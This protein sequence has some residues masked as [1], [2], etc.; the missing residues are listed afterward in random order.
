MSGH[1]DPRSRPSR[2]RPIGSR[3]LQSQRRILS[4][5]SQKLEGFVATSR[6]SSSKSEVLASSVTENDGTSQ[7]HA[8]SKGSTRWQLGN[9]SGG[10]FSDQHGSETWLEEPSVESPTS[11]MVDE[12][13][14]TRS[15]PG[16]SSF[17]LQKKS[18]S[19]L[20]N[21]LKASTSHFS[22]HPPASDSD[23]SDSGN[24]LARAP[25][26]AR[27]ER[28]RQHVMAASLPAS[29]PP[30]PRILP[31]PSRPQTPKLPRFPRLG[32]RQVVEH[33]REAAVDDSRG[34]ADELLQICWSAR[35]PDS[36]RQGK[37][38][39]DGTLSSTVGS[40]LHLP[41]VS[42]TTLNSFASGSTLVQAPTTQKVFNIKRPASTVS[43][44]SN[45][46]LVMLLHDAILRYAT[47]NS[48]RLPHETLV[49][50]TL[51]KPF[52]SS[53]N[54]QNVDED[55]WTAIEAFEVAVR[56]WQP[57]SDDVRGYILRFV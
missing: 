42:S 19:S 4:T 51:L 6:S 17:P 38:E 47:K 44:G 11:Y 55:R 26:S 50:S 31:I 5:D 2:L 33:A 29:P 52:L 3:P 28:L 40:S 34:F 20:S 37:H 32:F 53:E 14:S 45:V 46:S 1:Q 7:I 25:S 27:W 54:N 24:A 18:F 35:V 48:T 22:T 13:R 41:F 21:A 23:L 49:L 36:A 12:Q 10:L 43:T 15:V 30:S 39:R 57:K 56:T 8:P 16:T 9:S